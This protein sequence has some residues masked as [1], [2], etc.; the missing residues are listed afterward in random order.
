M[1][2]EHIDLLGHQTKL[3]ADGWNSNSMVW[4]LAVNREKREWRVGHST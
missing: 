1:R 3:R 2:Y 4:P